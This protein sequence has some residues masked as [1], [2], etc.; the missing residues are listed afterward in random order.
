MRVETMDDSE[1]P[2]LVRLDPGFVDC[3]VVSADGHVVNR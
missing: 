1:L 2:P 3:A